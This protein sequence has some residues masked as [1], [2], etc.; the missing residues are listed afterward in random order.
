MSRLQD[1][2][3]QIDTLCQELK[4]E[5][6]PADTVISS[7]AALLA[8]LAQGGR[9]RL[10]PGIY[11]G[12][13][14]CRKP[15]S[16][17]GPREAILVPL[18]IFTPTLTVLS[19][20]VT[21]VGFTIQ[22]GAPD[23]ECV[24]VGSFGATSAA[25]QPSYVI[26]D[27]LLVAAGAKGGHRGIAL[28]GAH[29]TVR[30]CR[31]TNF[32]ELGRESQGI[33]IHNGPGPYTIES[34]Y[35]EASGE[36]IMVGGDTVKIPGCVPADII[37]RGNVCYKPDAWRT[38]GAFVKNGIELKMGR[39][40][41][42]ENN[43]IDGN[44]KNGQVGTPIVITTRNQ[45]NDSPWVVIDEVIVRGNV[46]KRCADGYALSILGRDNNHPSGQTRRILV[47]HNLFTDS[48][49]GVIVTNGVADDLTIRR[50][51]FPGIAG[52]FLAFGDGVTSSPVVTPLTFT[53]NV[54]KHGEYGM[55]AGSFGF[56]QVVTFKAFT[57]NVIERDPRRSVFGP[58][59]EQI[60]TPAGNTWVEPGQLASLLDPTTLQLKT[61]TAGY[62]S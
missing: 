30:G 2:V 43:V 9:Y 14:V 45:Y 46:T 33:W 62:A 7:T 1:L 20:D 25:D 34:N 11:A 29:L 53:H 36:N 41:L 54:F 26:L 31:I 58:K 13:F 35:V 38:S 16:L 59:P 49:R 27:G 40:V 47:E 6:T 10:A 21:L 52:T 57:G 5:I 44:W 18:D 60:P 48:P 22:N 28:H 50:N 51:T 39:R 3:N 55:N 15:V 37:I 4:R 32:F 19:N 8:A 12:N 23:R 42:I 56:P 61:G 24:V 17:H